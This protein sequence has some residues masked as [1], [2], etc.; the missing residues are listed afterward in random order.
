MMKYEKPRL[1]DISQL[2]IAVGQCR[3]GNTNV[4][5]CI[6]GDQVIPMCDVGGIPTIDC[7]IGGSF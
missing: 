1:I 6:G 2:D 3:D 7:D 5:R 4:E